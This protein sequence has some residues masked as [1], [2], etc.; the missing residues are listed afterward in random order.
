[1][2]IALSNKMKNKTKYHTVGTILKLNIK[3]AERDNMDIHNTQLHDFPGLLQARQ[4]KWW[5]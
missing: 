3:M 4:K 2:T 1:M 5:S